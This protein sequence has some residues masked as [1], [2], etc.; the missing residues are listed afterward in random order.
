MESGFATSEDAATHDAWFRAKVE[1]AM[2]STAPKV[3]HDQVMAKARR[4]I[5]RRRTT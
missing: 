1:Q 4:I 5:D 2:A 3:P